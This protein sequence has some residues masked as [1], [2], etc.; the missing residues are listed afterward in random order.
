MSVQTIT[1]TDGSGQNPVTVPVSP[2]CDREGACLDLIVEVEV[3]VGVPV[4]VQLSLRT[5]GS[6]QLW[7]TRVGANASSYVHVVSRM[8]GYDRTGTPILPTPTEAQRRT[9]ARW[10][11]GAEKPLGLRNGV[12]ATL[13]KWAFEGMEMS[14]VQDR[15]LDGAQVFIA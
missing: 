13:L 8:N 14:A 7:A 6:V 11:S 3:H 9:V 4:A 2:R 15:Y 12:G 5:D 10:W 1:I